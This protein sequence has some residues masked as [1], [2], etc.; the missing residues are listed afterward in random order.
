MKEPGPAHPISIVANP[1]RIRV[2]AGE[3]VIADTT[4]ALTLRET[5]L[6]AVHYIPREDTDMTLLS[7]TAHS[8]HCPFKGDASYFTVNADGHA[9][10]NAVWSYEQP[11]PAVAEIRERLAFYPNK[12]RIEEITD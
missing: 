10:E 5:T 9:A 3:R 2:F 7:R 6:P 1:N 11:F 12:V 4:H 8:T